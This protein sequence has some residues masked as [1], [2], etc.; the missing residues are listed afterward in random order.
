FSS[1]STV[2][3][4]YVA[5][6]IDSN[7]TRL[8]P[9]YATDANS[10][11]VGALIYNSLLRPDAASNLHGDLAE[12]WTMTDD[13]T[14]VFDLRRGVRFHDGR[15][16][17]A[18][19]V[20]STYEF[21]LKPENR[22][23]KRGPLSVIRSID[24]LGPYRIRFRLAAPFA[25][26]L[27]HCTVGIV[28]GGSPGAA[29]T[30]ESR[31]PAGSGPFILDSMDSGSSI[32]LKANP[33]YWDGVPSVAGLIFKIIP[34]AMVRVLEFKK[35]TLHLLQN[36]IEPDLLPWIRRHTDA[37]VETHRGTTF[38]YIGINLTHPILR[39]RKVRQA[40]ALAIDRDAIIEHLLKGQ[41][42]PATGLLS[43]LHWAYAGSVRRW[44]YDPEAAK[45]LL[46]EAGYPDPDGDGP[47]P[48]FRLSFKTTQ[49]D[50]RRRIA[51]AFK[52]QLQ[53]VGIELEVRSYEWGTFY[54]DIKKGNFHLFSLAWVGIR[55]PDIYYDLFHSAA[56][57]PNGDNRGRYHN[58]A[59]DKLLEQGRRSTDTNERK[60]IY[61]RIQMILARD[62]PYIPLWWVKNVVVRTP[63]LRGF[64]SYPDGDFISLK[65]VSLHAAA[66][67]T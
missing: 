56:I 13:R 17:T 61:R 64:V 43:P 32:V 49:I 28:P 39:H 19:D 12:R 47:R 14:Y 36:D 59:V 31:P 41:A 25:P 16:L 53:Q 44:R 30:G 48:R 40:L 18:K 58:V 57:P 35:G 26:F 6:G 66:P 33:S 62:L 65:R 45:K 7:P 27:E 51:E 42:T 5:I 15:P 1:P 22:S 63:S 4:G 34:D 54:S 38:Q 50:L 20:K 60:L 21:I 10:V 2:P 46:D 23:P 37:I 24:E 11:R 9:R 55:D 52:N 29:I 67:R 3:P 8:D